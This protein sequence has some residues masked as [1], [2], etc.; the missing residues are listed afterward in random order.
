MDRFGKRSMEYTEKAFRADPRSLIALHKVC[1][2][3]AG[4]PRSAQNPRRRH[5]LETS[6]MVPFLS[7]GCLALP[8]STDE[9]RASI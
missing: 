8:E 1:D 4:V 9:H 6:A 7:G 2:S 5:A 3:P